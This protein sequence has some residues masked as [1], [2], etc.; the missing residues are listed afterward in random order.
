MILKIVNG[1]DVSQKIN[2]RLEGLKSSQKMKAIKTVLTG[3]DAT[4]FNEDRLEPAIKPVTTT[5]TVN[6]DF[7]YT[8]PANSFTVYRMDL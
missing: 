4:A 5:E 3:P 8:A 1:D 7:T 6:P 2:I